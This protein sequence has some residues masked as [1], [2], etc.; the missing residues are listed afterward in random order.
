MVPSV[1]TVTLR[2]PSLSVLKTRDGT[3]GRR[4]VT[5]SPSFRSFSQI[6]RTSSVEVDG[7]G[8]TETRDPSER[9]VSGCPDHW[10]LD[11][12]CPLMSHVWFRAPPGRVSFGWSVVWHLLFTPS[13]LLVQ[14]IRT[15]PLCVSLSLGDL[16][17]PRCLPWVVWS[18]LPSSPSTRS[19]G[20][21]PFVFLFLLR[22]RPSGPDVSSV[23]GPPGL[24]IHT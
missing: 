16:G 11:H 9:T 19:I 17:P 14:V 15:G 24:G 12:P 1:S 18:C 5:I 21:C 22:R 23:T 2:I 3:R 20:L 13:F 4:G 10:N 6:P 8:F 7:M